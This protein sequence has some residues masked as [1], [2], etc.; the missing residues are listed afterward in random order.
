MTLTI[1]NPKIAIA[2]RVWKRVKV[3]ARLDMID[4][5]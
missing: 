2:A 1:M 3:I 4:S 5:F